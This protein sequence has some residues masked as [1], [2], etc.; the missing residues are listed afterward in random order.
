MTCVYGGRSYKC[1][2]LFSSIYTVQEKKKK[3]GPWNLLIYRP[4]ISPE[5][6]QITSVSYFHPPAPCLALLLPFSL[7]VFASV[8]LP[9]LH[10]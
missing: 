10:S 7:A 1:L 6:E 9:G 3:T 5:E 2:G 8:F 4:Q